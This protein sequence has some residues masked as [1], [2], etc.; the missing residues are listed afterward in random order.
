MKKVPAPPGPVAPTGPEAATAGHVSAMTSALHY[1]PELKCSVSSLKLFTTFIV[2]KLALSIETVQI[3]LECQSVF[4]WFL[5]IK[6]FHLSA[7]FLT[8]YL[9]CSVST[10]LTF[11]LSKLW[12]RWLDD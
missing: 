12:P 4:F 6:W 2:R 11:S 10:L 5:H 7:T 9:H 3:K 8:Q 1:Q